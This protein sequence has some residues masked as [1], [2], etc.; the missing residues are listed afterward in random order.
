MYIEKPNIKI[1]VYDNKKFILLIKIFKHSLFKKKVVFK[2]L[3]RIIFK[4]D[5]SERKTF[6]RA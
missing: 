1:Y 3:F 5:L 6:P 2:Y 4:F